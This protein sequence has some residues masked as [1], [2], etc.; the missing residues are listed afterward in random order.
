LTE[1][2]SDH[3]VGGKSV[4]G[5]GMMSAGFDAS[6]AKIAAADAVQVS[7]VTA[8]LVDAFSLVG[9]LRQQ[10]EDGELAEAFSDHG[11]IWIL[12]HGIVVLNVV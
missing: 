2:F 7:A 10:L 8:A 4:V 6:T 11:G 3:V 5:S 12:R 9:A 1:L